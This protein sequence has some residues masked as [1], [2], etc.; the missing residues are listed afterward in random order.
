MTQKVA[1]TFKRGYGVYNA[2]ETAGFDPDHAFDLIN[3]GIAKKAKDQPK[4]ATSTVAL[5]L[6][7]QDMPEFLEVK[8]ALE[9]AGQQID[10]RSAALDQREAE[11]NTRESELD[12]RSADLD[13]LADA[14]AEDDAGETV[15]ETV[16][17]AGE[18]IKPDAD[19]AGE[20][21]AEKPAGLPKQGRGGA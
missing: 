13:A 20:K 3:A 14:L 11:L 18:V 21:A 17:E 5:S 12:R 1:V 15:I 10:Q 2:G 4:P 8:K 6:N 19:A 7:I 16:T 9:D